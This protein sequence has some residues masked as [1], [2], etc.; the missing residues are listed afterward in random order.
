[1]DGW[2]GKLVILLGTL[3]LVVGF[4][5]AV[6]F[7]VPGPMVKMT[8]RGLWPPKSRAA[9]KAPSQDRT[10]LASCR[11]VRCLRQATGQANQAIAPRVEA[12][13]PD[14]SSA[15]PRIPSGLPARSPLAAGSRPPH[16]GHEHIAVE[17]LRQPD[18]SRHLASRLAS[19]PGLE[20]TRPHWYNSPGWP[21][22]SGLKDAARSEDPLD[23]RTFVG[24]LAGGLLA[25]PL[26][27]GA[28]QPDRVPRLGLLLP[29]IESDLQAQARVTAFK[30][31]LQARGWTDGRNVRFEFRYTNGQPDR[32]P[33]LAA[34]LVKRTSTSS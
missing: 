4:V 10:S 15:E 12:V 32:L 25:V 20:P 9:R 23:R 28:Q 18:S 22:P 5:L 16:R 7:L 17:R 33:A 21:P 3:G 29:Y 26:A 31:A 24:M 34:E 6:F 1:M 13:L 19:L 8:W 2:M 30:A 11:W 27:A 14:A